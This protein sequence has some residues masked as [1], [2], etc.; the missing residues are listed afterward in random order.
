MFGSIFLPIFLLQDALFKDL[1]DVWK[2]T[3]VILTVSSVKINR[4]RKFND[5]SAYEWYLFQHRF[6]I[7]FRFPLSH[8][9]CIFQLLLEYDLV[10]ISLQ[11]SCTDSML[12]SDQILCLCMQF[13]YWW[14]CI[15]IRWH[16]CTWWNDIT[17]KS[18]F[19]YKRLNT[20]TVITDNLCTVWKMLSVLIQYLKAFS[21]KT[22]DF[23]QHIIMFINRSHNADFM[24]TCSFQMMKIRS[25]L[26]LSA[27]LA[28]S[29]H[30]LWL[31]AFQVDACIGWIKFN[32]TTENNIFLYFWNS[33]VQLVTHIKACN[34]AQFSSNCLLLKC[35]SIQFTSYKSRPCI[36]T[37]SWM[38]KH[39]T[40]SSHEYWTAVLA[41]PISVCALDWIHSLQSV[42][43]H[44]EDISV[45]VIQYFHSL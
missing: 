2:N 25:R 13:I 14:Y 42:Q 26:V 21:S 3:I 4:H 32:I 10:K 40:G 24:M 28:H 34:Y 12:L 23:K 37:C 41:S 36:K 43:I 1:V 19:R 8:V 31:C 33:L 20:V 39:G 22:T 27:M 5:I 11:M 30:V 17:F 18:V 29:R 9:Q 6:H 38:C 44:S 7:C 16:I 15:S 45:R 35:K